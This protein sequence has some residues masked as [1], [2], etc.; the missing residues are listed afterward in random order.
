MSRYSTKQPGIT[1]QPHVGGTIAPT[2]RAP[3]PETITPMETEITEDV[4]DVK[5]EA[6]ELS[7][8]PMT[9]DKT[10]SEIPAIEKKEADE[11][12]PWTGRVS[13]TVDLQPVDK[14]REV[15]VTEDDIPPKNKSSEE[16]KVQSDIEEQINLLN[17]QG[18]LVYLP[19]K[20]VSPTAQHQDESDEFFEHTEEEVRKMMHD[21]ISQN[22]QLQSA[23]LITAQLRREQ[24]EK[25]KLQLLQKYPTTVLRVHFSDA[26]ILQLPLSSFLTLAEVKRQLLEYLDV[27]MKVDNFELFTTPPKHILET[28]LPLHELGLT[29][30]SHVYISSNCILNEK[31]RLNPS[32]YDGAVRAASRQL[33]RPTTTGLSA[34]DDIGV[35]KE[36][37]P[38]RPAP[39]PSATA[40][41][42]EKNV[43]KWLKLKR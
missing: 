12:K 41:S 21:L 7:E 9:E 33:Y 5:M 37:R 27:S 25:R 43:P 13:E 29:P 15:E 39:E 3:S 19:P 18:A 2:P 8:I 16:S 31:F 6:S 11:A 10:M 36:Q 38:K 40:I 17:E 1:E 34:N 24:E 22:N 42:I 28:S 26:F 4:N 14:E 35:F 23:P 32:S 20:D 30:S